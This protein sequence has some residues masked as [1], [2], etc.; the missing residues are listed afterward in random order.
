MADS[1]VME[2]VKPEDVY[3]VDPVIAEKVHKGTLSQQIED[4]K[5]TIR[6]ARSSRHPDAVARIPEYKAR[7]R[8][9]EIG[10]K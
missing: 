8:V 5:A 6:R 9:L 2:F 7:L 1:S 3:E 4:L 10:Q